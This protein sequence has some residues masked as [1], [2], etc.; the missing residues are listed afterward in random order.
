MLMVK[1]FGC[2][3]ALL[4][5]TNVEHRRLAQQLVSLLRD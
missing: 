5:R 2:A 3:A 4:A 1:A